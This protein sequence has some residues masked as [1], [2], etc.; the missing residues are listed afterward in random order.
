M[1]GRGAIWEFERRQGLI[2]E[3]LIA[4]AAGIGD[5]RPGQGVVIVTGSSSHAAHRVAGSVAVSRA[6]R[7]PVPLV[8]VP[9]ARAA[10]SPGP[11]P[12]IRRTRTVTPPSVRNYSKNFPNDPRYHL[13]APA[14]LSRCS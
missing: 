10:A 13:L 2:A 9:E 4:V 1:R 5:A 14:A 7:A 11:D 12:G 8:I 6:R 3:E